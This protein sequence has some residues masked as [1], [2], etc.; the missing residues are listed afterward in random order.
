MV[1]QIVLDQKS[2]DRCS[3]IIRNIEDCP[4]SQL[5]LQIVL[6]FRSYVFVL[7]TYSDNFKFL[8]RSLMELK[9]SYS[10]IIELKLFTIKED[11]S[12]LKGW[13]YLVI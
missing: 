9:N 2:E 7:S 12:D 8:L 1:Y 6:S 13:I 4:G 3:N 11:V 10:L 5:F